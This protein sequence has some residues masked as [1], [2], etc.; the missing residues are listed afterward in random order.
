MALAR[1][2][3]FLSY[4]ARS[5]AEIRSKL[6]RLGFPHKIIEA[7]LEKLRSLNLI[8]DE[9]FARSWALGRVGDRGYGPLRIE[10]EL[11]QKGVARSLISRILE[12][13]F[14]TQEDKERARSL[15]AK[16]FRYKDLNDVKIFRRA[17]AF[18]QRRGYRDAM[19]AELLKPK[20]PIGDD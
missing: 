15:L 2:L 20:Q 1:A 5:E 16:R 3:K 14:S 11:R 17:V 4:R 6:T 7:T 12:E 18:L 13:T 8:N 19:I 9:D 10:S